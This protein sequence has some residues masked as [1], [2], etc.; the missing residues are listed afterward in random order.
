M[1]SAP[2]RHFAFD[3]CADI[4]AVNR[5]ARF[6][7][8]DFDAMPARDRNMTAWMLTDPRARSLYGPAWEEVA[9]TMTGALRR[10]AGRQPGNPRVTELVRRLSDDSALFRNAWRRHD[11]GTCTRMINRLHHPAGTLEF[12]SDIVTGRQRQGH[13][14]RSW[15]LRSTRPG[16][17]LSSTTIP[18]LNQTK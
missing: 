14:V 13:H 5:A 11:I 4:V 12:V 2:R 3:D 8:A 18:A 15:P 17:L 16:S 7:F 6:L 1:P 10:T 9:T